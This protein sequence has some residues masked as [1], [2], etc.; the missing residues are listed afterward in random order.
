MIVQLK[1]CFLPYEDKAEKH[2]NN[3]IKNFLFW[4]PYSGNVPTWK[5]ITFSKTANP[6]NTK[7]AP[8]LSLLIRSSKIN[9]DQN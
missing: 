9:N 8:F 5:H 7:L 2:R 4:T 1:L 6:F 3:T